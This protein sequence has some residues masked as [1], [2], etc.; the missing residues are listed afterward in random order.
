MNPGPGG[1][2]LNALM[3]N[4][5]KQAEQA[6]QR[7]EADLRGKTVEGST[8]GGLVK[9][10]ATGSGEVRGVSIDPSLLE[11]GEKDMLE[12]LIAA[13]VNVALKKA[14][15]LRAEAEKGQLGNMLGGMGGMGGLGGGGMPDLNQLLGGLG[16]LGGLGPS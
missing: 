1:F 15:E 9:V 13:A 16:G 12:D 2:D 4:A 5:M 14:G 6:K 11:P 8:G 3:G 7:L 10:S